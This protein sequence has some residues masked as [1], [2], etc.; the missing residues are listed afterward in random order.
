MATIWAILASALEW[1]GTNHIDLTEKGLRPCIE[2]ENGVY[3]LR[4][5]LFGI[6]V[7]LIL[8]HVETGVAQIKEAQKEAD[9]ERQSGEDKQILDVQTHAELRSILDHV[10]R[11]L[12]PSNCDDWKEGDA[13]VI[14]VLNTGA[15]KELWVGN[16]YSE[17]QDFG[18]EGLQRTYEIKNLSKGGSPMRGSI[19]I[20]LP[21]R[22]MV[23]ERACF[24]KLKGAQVRGSTEDN[25][26]MY[27]NNLWEM[28][29][30]DVKFGVL[31][32]P[33]VIRGPRVMTGE[34]QVTLVMSESLLAMV[35]RKAAE[36]LWALP[37]S[38]GLMIMWSLGGRLVRR[39]KTKRRSTS[40]HSARETPTHPR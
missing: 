23:I 14:A 33:Q 27:R 25:N 3:I 28:T 16:K 35:L 36:H 40:N 26:G 9:S 10:K 30:T 34:T 11:N 20:R 6:I 13:R 4:P 19:Q 22:E 32:K 12:V 15:L 39:V 31:V 8:G 24:K 37:G 7:I 17:S 1:M 18:I 29:I 5:I 38:L 2:G 21:T